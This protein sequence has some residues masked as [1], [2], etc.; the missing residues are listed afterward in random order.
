MGLF[1]WPQGI[2]REGDVLMSERVGAMPMSPL[3]MFLDDLS[4]GDPVLFKNV[5]NY[6]AKSMAGPEGQVVSPTPEPAITDDAV[7]APAYGEGAVENE[8]KR[9]EMLKGL[10]I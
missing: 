5:M 3:Q 4:K 9:R 8:K 10:S 1:D 6:Y 7:V 2:K